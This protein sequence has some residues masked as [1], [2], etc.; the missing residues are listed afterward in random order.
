MKRALS[1][2]ATVAILA[3]PAFQ[4]KPITI[5]GSDTMV[6]LGQR[7]AEEYMNSHPGVIVQVTGGGSGVGIAALINGTT[8]VCEASRAMKGSERD[9]LRDRYFTT[10]VE[11]AVAKDGI[12]FYL[13]EA[14]PVSELSLSQIKDIYTG[15]IT[16]WK[17]VG[18]PDA[19]II[20]YGRENS[21]GTYV[22]VKDNVLNGAD[23]APSTQTLPGT[24]AI[25]N[26]V[27]KDKYGIGYGGVGYAK[28]VKH[29]RVKKDA[30]SP[31][32][33]P[34][35]ENVMTGRYPVSRDLYWYL[36]EK[37][38][39]QI[40]NL[41]DWVLSPGGQEIVTKVGYFPVKSPHRV[42]RNAAGARLPAAPPCP[43]TESEG[44]TAR[45][46]TGKPRLTE[47]SI[48]AL[49][50]FV[51]MS[52]IA[53]ILLIFVFVM[54]EALPIFTDPRVQ[55]EA[56]IARFFSTVVWQ[57]VSDWPRYG[58]APLILGT[59]KVTLVALLFAIPVGVGAALFTSEF[60]HPRVKEFLKPIV[61]LLAGIP[62]VV[63]GF[64]ALMVLASIL[65]SIFHYSSRLNALNAG[66]AL[67]IAVIPTIFSV[68]EDAL[69]AVPRSLR[70]ASYA[71]GGDPWQT[72]W[73][74]TLPPH[75]LVSWPAFSLVWAARF[76]Q[77]MIVLM[78]SGNASLLTASLF[79]STRTLAAT[80]AAELG[81]VVFGEPHYNTLFF[82]G[83][84]LFS[85]TFAVN[86]GAHVMVGRLK[87]KLAGK[88]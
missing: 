44:M 21:S 5:K 71:L 87:R 68:S 60:A 59:L 39:G 76:G 61:E 64:L 22:F 25:V 6:I 84:L 65:Q 37:P 35:K 34:T 66:I 38:T 13:N 57:P 42:G 11:I 20:L 51:A 70:E 88:L 26:A 79:D 62:S 63:L 17:Q 19:K 4:A 29:T 27:A 32:Y 78:A 7:W 56:S 2:I 49:I 86:L 28:G 50:A 10:G 52:T 81:E 67:G 83:T 80:I 40:K 77:T 82:I 36:R 55:A 73:W 74:V 15:K 8:D 54:R 23:Y 31:A 24:A 46:L 45:S 12:T 18:G 48:E 9:K 33:E 69:N 47:R 30:Q 43:E 53:S 72:A 14:N 75:R 16:N 41:V 58:F 85:L 1:L 3:I